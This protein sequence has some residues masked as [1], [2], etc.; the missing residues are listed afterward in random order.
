LGGPPWAAPESY[1]AASPLLHAQSI[2]A[3]VLMMNAD[4]DWF[5]V[6]EFEA[7]TMALRRLGKLACLATYWGEGHGNS[8]PANIRHAWDL[9][10]RWLEATM[11]SRSTVAQVCR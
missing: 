4:M 1:V 3:P 7:M 2:E 8:S 6:G 5:D 10:T 9:T 11:M